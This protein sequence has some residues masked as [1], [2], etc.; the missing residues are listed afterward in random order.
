MM[1]VILT[2]TMTEVIGDVELRQE[3]GEREEW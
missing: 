2:M 3:G 1:K